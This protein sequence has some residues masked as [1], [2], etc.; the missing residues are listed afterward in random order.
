M[1]VRTLYLGPTLNLFLLKNGVKFIPL[2]S[3]CN[4][5]CGGVVNLPLQGGLHKDRFT[6]FTVMLSTK[7]D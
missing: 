3:P 2:G 5:L 4:D 7:I 6:S 1:S